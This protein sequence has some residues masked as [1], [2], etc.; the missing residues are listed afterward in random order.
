MRQALIVTNPK[1]EPFQAVSDKFKGLTGAA[2]L[3]VRGRSKEKR[4]EAEKPAFKKK[5]AD[6]PEAHAADLRKQGK[7][8]E[9]IKKA[10][11]AFGK[12]VA[13]AATIMLAFLS[14]SA[15]G[16]ADL[17]GKLPATNLAGSS[18]NYAGPAWAGLAVD[19]VAV[20]SITT[21]CTNSSSP[22]VASNL[23]VYVDTQLSGTGWLTNAYVL[24]FTCATN[25]SSRTAFAKMTNTFGGQYFRANIANANTNYVVASD[26]YWRAKE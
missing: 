9:E 4:I 19:Q 21:V 5:E 8:V 22:S 11:E 23:V 2:V 18:T 25:T 16:Q 24:T 12:K 20:F 3:I 14:F 7:S 15:F 17:T 1:W 10:V 6:S 13:K 26:F